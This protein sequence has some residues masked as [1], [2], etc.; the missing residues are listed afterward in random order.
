VAA[1]RAA[2]P[3]ERK[4]IS[5]QLAAGRIL[6]RQAAD[7]HRGGE[8]VDNVEVK[9]AMRPRWIGDDLALIRPIERNAVPAVQGCTL[10]VPAVQERL[11]G[12][13]AEILPNARLRRWI[14]GEPADYPLAALPLALEPG[15]LPADAVR[16]PIMRTLAIA[17]IGIAIALG[18]LAALL[19]GVLALGE[20]RA[21]FV[22]AVSHELRTPITSL[23]MYAEMLGEGMVGDETKRAAYL[24]T[25]RAEA[26]RLGRLVENVLAYAR[27]ERRGDAGRVGA[28]PLAELLESLRERLARRVAEAGFALE[29]DF[30]AC[31]AERVQVDSEWVEQILFNLVDNACKYAGGGERRIGITAEAGAREVHL[32]VADHG[33]GIAADVRKR[34]FQPFSKSAREAAHSAPGVG[35]GLSLSRRLARRMGGELAVDA[36]G[37]DGTT[38]RLSLPKS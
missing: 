9:G 27:L 22:S 15:L 30:G 31:A 3:E 35:L 17:W 28:R 36:T 12:V 10:D 37:S 4:R 5:E 29:I 11:L 23:R 19:A 6:G 14:P 33:G 34:L 38:M 1:L 16:S 21:M 7:A 18:A 26:D 8:G 32:L 2:R 25:I 20:R 13:I 24:A